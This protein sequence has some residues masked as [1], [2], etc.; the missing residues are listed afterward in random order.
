MTEHT[1]D[2]DA[3]PCPHHK[4]EHV[5]SGGLRWPLTCDACRVIPPVKPCECGHPPADH[6][7]A[8]ACMHLCDCAWPIPPVVPAP[9]F[10]EAHRVTTTGDCPKCDAE[11]IGAG[12]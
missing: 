6:D 9:W 12:E 7:D 8:G 5:T 2:Y 10:C 11:L 3:A 4:A 1:A